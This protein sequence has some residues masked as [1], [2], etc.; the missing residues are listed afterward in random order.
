MGIRNTEEV[1]CWQIS[2]DLEIDLVS[3]ILL[4]LMARRL[5]G[6]HVKVCKIELCFS[7]FFYF[8]GGRCSSTSAVPSNCV[9]PLSKGGTN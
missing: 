6:I 7:E 8:I 2:V 1:V 9:L 3:V 4:K 5:K